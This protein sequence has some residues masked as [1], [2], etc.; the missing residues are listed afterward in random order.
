MYCYIFVSALPNLSR[1]VI[2]HSEYK[3]KSRIWCLISTMTRIRAGNK[4]SSLL[5]EPYLAQHIFVTI[6]YM[7]GARNRPHPIKSTI[8][9]GFTH[10]FRKGSRYV[11]GMH[12]DKYTMF[13]LFSTQP[14]LQLRKNLSLQFCLR[15]INGLVQEK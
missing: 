2:T 3:M 10:I 6:M 7:G 8:L 5:L 15:S 14:Q 1:D 4:G 9:I 12:G 11:N 13:F